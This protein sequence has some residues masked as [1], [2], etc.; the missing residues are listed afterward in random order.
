MSSWAKKLLL[1]A[2]FFPFL[3]TSVFL[4]RG[5]YSLSWLADTVFTFRKFYFCSNMRFF[6]TFP[7][8]IITNIFELWQES[9]KNLSLVIFLLH[10]L[11]RSLVWT[12][13]YQKQI[14]YP[15]QFFSEPVIHPHCLILCSNGLHCIASF[16]RF[17]FLR[18]RVFWLWW[19]LIT[20]KEDKASSKHHHNIVEPRVEESLIRSVLC[21]CVVS[22]S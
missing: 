17:E 10:D 7:D 16:L 14:I 9:E 4:R 20:E 6:C 11:G 2:N 3:E 1:E 13:Y 5:R 22:V 15:T 12:S 18:R 8:K 21:S 19:N